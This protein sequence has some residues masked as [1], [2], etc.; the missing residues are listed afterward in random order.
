MSTLP[1]SARSFALIAAGLALFAL[2]AL[3]DACPD[4]QL[5]QRA[6]LVGDGS[7]GPA[8]VHPTHHERH[9]RHE[10]TTGAEPS[11]EAPLSLLDF[12]PN[13]DAPAGPY[14]SRPRRPIRLATRLRA[15]SAALLEAT[16]GA[17]F[18][19]GSPAA[20]S[21]G[22]RLH[23]TIAQSEEELVSLFLRGGD[24]GGADFI[25]LSLERFMA[26]LPELVPASPKIFLLLSTSRGA[27]TLLA[28]SHVH[29]LGALRGRRVAHAQTEAGLHFL[30]W[31]LLKAGVAHSSLELR[32]ASSS[33]QALR[34]LRAGLVDA[35]LIHELE[36]AQPDHDL[37]DLPVLAIDDIQAPQD[38]SLPPALAEA[39]AEAVFDP[40]PAVTTDGDA[41]SAPARLHRLASTADA[42]LL[43]PHVLIGRGAFLARY[44]EVARRTAR[45]LLAEADEIAA[46]P[47]PAARCLL[48]Q[49]PTLPD[50]R[51]SIALDPPAS[52][53]ENRAF[54]GLN[55]SPAPL[56]YADLFASLDRVFRK[57]GYP[58]LDSP[59]EPDDFFWDVALQ[60]LSTRNAA[61]A[62]R[63]MPSRSAAA[64]VAR[65]ALPQP[66]S[67]SSSSSS[68]EPEARAP[69][70]ATSAEADS[71]PLHSAEESLSAAEEPVS[72]ALPDPDDAQGALPEEMAT[73]SDAPP[74]DD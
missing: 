39:E 9:E 40:E 24:E 45:A 19:P 25:A 29:S 7:G 64:A 8:R 73:P 32:P 41:P 21:H 74:T 49:L 4:A 1:F 56:S 10:R 5:R 35:A 58:G 69:A 46:D 15:S 67:S 11:A 59:A 50:P 54:F 6:E 36:L 72:P 53:A 43:V 68:P 22:V 38:T 14:A 27:E 65:A 44:P 20:R 55:K 34:W 60:G 30:Y 3:Q 57:L 23:L 28:G 16:G 18:R 61:S 37:P 17:G 70:E 13:A 31:R 47:L 42:P 52:L 71:A 48:E 63:S 66:P 26:R 12:P 33:A 2:F 51:G 62:G